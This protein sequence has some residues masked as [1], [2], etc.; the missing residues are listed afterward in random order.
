MSGLYVVLS[1]R[2]E[3]LVQELASELRRPVARPLAS[4]WILIQGRGMERF[5]SLRL[6]RELGVAANLRFP[7][8]GRFIEDML[9]RASGPGLSYAL[10]LRRLTFRLAAVLPDEMSR[11]EFADVRQYV[12]SGDDLRLLRFARQV[13]DVFD[14]YAVHRPEMQS[15]WCAGDFESLGQTDVWQALLWRR[16]ADSFLV[17]DPLAGLALLREKLSDTKVRSEIFPERL[18][19]F[20]VSTVRGMHRRVL[21][22]LALFCD[23]HVY[24]L[25]ACEEPE[26]TESTG[27]FLDRLQSTGAEFRNF[28]EAEAPATGGSVR[29]RFAVPD[30]GHALGRLQKRLLLRSATHRPRAHSE[31]TL[32]PAPDCSVSFASC[33]TP[34]REVEVLRDHLLDAFSRRADLTPSEVLVL[35]PD[36]TEYAPLV[37]AVFGNPESES[38]RIPFHVADSRPGEGAD[39]ISA[40]NA[41]HEVVQ[42]RMTARQVLQLLEEGPIARHFRLEEA[43][44][45][46]V[47]LW[48]RETGIRWGWD[49]QD[50]AL[51][52][53]PAFAEG[54]WQSGLDRLLLGLAFPTGHGDIFG[55]VSPFTDVEGDGVEVLGR[56]ADLVHALHTLAGAVAETRTA[57]GWAG[58]VR[59]TLLSFTGSDVEEAPAL[60]DL[61]SSWEEAP[62]Q[63]GLTALFQA[64]AFLAQIIELPLEVS[65]G[66]G[67]ASGG[68]LFAALLPMRAVPYRLVCLLGMNEDAFPGKDVVPEFHLLY[69][70]GDPALPQRRT[71]DRLLFLETVLS[72]RDELYISYVGQ[73]MYSNRQRQPSVVVTEIRD[74]LAA[75]E[76]WNPDQ[77]SRR[78]RLQGHAQAYF[79]EGDP[80]TLFSYST[81]NRSA[82]EAAISERKNPRP[83][84][85]RPLPP[86]EQLTA[87][88]LEELLEFFRAP[89]RAFLQKRFA[90][91]PRSR[92]EAPAD[93]EDVL[94]NALGSWKILEFLLE[95]LAGGR[96]ESELLRVCRARGFL[97]PGAVG[98]LSFT[99]ELGRARVFAAQL[100]AALPAGLPMRL[101]AQVA[102]GTEHLAGR[103]LLS[104]HGV[105]VQRGGALRGVDFLGAWIQHL[106]L[107]LL[108]PEQEAGRETIL[109]GRRRNTLQLDIVRFDSLSR[110]EAVGFLSDLLLIYRTGLCEPLA[111]LP[112]SSFLF[113]QTRR[114][115]GEE[116][117]LRDA[118][119][120]F[121]SEYLGYPQ[122]LPEEEE[123][124]IAL[125][126]R[127]R[128]PL[129]GL[130]E[131]FRSLAVRIYE[132][133]LD[134]CIEVPVNWEA[135][136]VARGS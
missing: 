93:E 101:D 134:R 129:A 63:L 60:R 46:W 45:E 74:A 84:L 19:L 81:R 106:F 23:V 59:N 95:Q 31:G 85:S 39:L 90:F 71:D 128:D 99:R 96:P 98:D 41:I 4:E 78:H 120:A 34:H 13:A 49:A 16:L 28:L 103:L 26:G 116:T 35:T 62:I 77:I 18:F 70:D 50:R 136:F 91:R 100:E 88:S 83:F 32:A 24:C 111:F 40:L 33:H 7:Y 6:A 30:E 118:Q 114:T 122:P 1:N 10:D 51:H 73:D 58:F 113:A 36:I 3:E 53:V 72:A 20:G 68:V 110:D 87:P 131:D 107:Q 132:P 130:A 2:T 102:V 65:S 25:S 104:R 79:D 105:L 121:Y 5:L 12:E 57:G 17:Q 76:G 55:G 69:R 42:G 80:A 15:A 8:P 133:L 37:E 119:K 86:A 21:R 56:L 92:L 64:E 94:P 67:F 54:S 43:E 61:L 123:P 89:G 14:Q 48:L 126:F 27:E 11:P 97:S 108:P 112:R 66:K 125:C 75:A 38:T 29:R 117:A 109:V 47:R 52:G 127:G 44:L 115:K 135:S 9:A 22:E 82:S 124:W